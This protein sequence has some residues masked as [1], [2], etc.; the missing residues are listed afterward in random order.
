MRK[1]VTYDPRGMSWDSWCSFMNELFA[2]QQLGTM[3]EERWQEWG[4]AVAGIGYFGN[5]AVP[6]TRGFNNWQDWAQQFVG[7][8]SIK[9]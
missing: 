2:S 6:D 7:I 3:P 1:M 5:S 9:P 8:M 4:T